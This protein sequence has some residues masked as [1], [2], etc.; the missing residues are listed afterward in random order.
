MSWDPK[1]TPVMAFLDFCSPAQWTQEVSV[2]TSLPGG[3]QFVV[4]PGRW[5]QEISLT[6]EAGPPSD[7]SYLKIS[8]LGWGDSWVRPYILG[9][10]PTHGLHLF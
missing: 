7:M 3:W 2:I 5:T 10:S 4:P 9:I 1:L 8:G 6:S